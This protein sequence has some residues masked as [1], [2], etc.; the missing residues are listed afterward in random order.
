MLFHG[1]CVAMLLL[2]AARSPGQASIALPPHPERVGMDL[3]T[4]LERR[5]T[6]RA[7]A[8]RHL[9]LDE[10][11]AI[12]W[13]GNGVNRP[14][15]KRTAPS[16]HGLQYVELYLVLPEAA[17]RYDAPGHR[18][19]RVRRGD[20]RAQLSDQPQVGAAPAV[21]VIVGDLARLP[22]PPAEEVRWRW[23]HATAGT[24]AQNIALMA[25]ARGLGTG[26]VGGLDAKAISRALGLS[27]SAQPLYVMPLGEL[28]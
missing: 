12:L 26:I 24:I 23:V 20:L 14:D 22:A 15:G 2:G 6:A 8:P 28:R 5:H 17:Y 1:A 4:A 25:A 9:M 16:A 10:L 7:F 21:I 18:L 11:S 27:G 3:V 13:A 19:E